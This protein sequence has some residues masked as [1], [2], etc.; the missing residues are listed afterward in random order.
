[1]YTRTRVRIIQNKMKIKRKRERCG[2]TRVC[3]QRREKDKK[4]EENWGKKIEIRKGGNGE[5]VG[6]DGMGWAL[7]ELKKT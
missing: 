3:N 5:E 4:P 6:C 7:I 2:G 1:M